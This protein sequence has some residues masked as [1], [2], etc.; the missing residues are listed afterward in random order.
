M[1]ELLE[2]ICVRCRNRHRIDLKCWS[3]KYAQRLTRLV[4]RT[5]GSVCWICGGVATT[6]D[7]VVPRSRGGDDNL[8]ALRPCCQPCNSRR[9]NTENPFTPEPEVRASGVGLSKRW[10]P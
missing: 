6:A 1:T 9:G 3:G 7:H 4:L 10:R 2:P 8:E 5:Q